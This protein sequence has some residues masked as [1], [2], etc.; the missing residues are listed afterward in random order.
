MSFIQI[1]E[2]PFLCKSLLS[3][4]LQC[5]CCSL[6][7]WFRFL[8]SWLGACHQSESEFGTHVKCFH[9]S[10][11]YSLMLSLVQC[12]KLLFQLFC[13]VLQLTMARSKFKICYSVMTKTR[14]PHFGKSAVAAFPAINAIL[15]KMYLVFTGSI[16]KQNAC[17]L[18]RH[19]YPLMKMVNI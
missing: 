8:V 16:E 4:T 3:D 13:I 2:P 19:L 10:M 15:M 11:V 14:S 12:L 9:S 17:L 5:G 6:V 1:Y 18:L 7:S